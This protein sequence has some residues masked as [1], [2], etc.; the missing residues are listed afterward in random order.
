MRAMHERLRHTRGA[1]VAF[2][3]IRPD[4]D[5][6]TYLGVGNIFGRIALSGEKTRSLVS[7]NGTLGHELHKVQPFTYPWSRDAV[8]VMNS[9]GLL[10]NWDLA[11]CPGLEAQH[12]ALVAAVAWRDYR[13]VTD[14]A[15][16]VAVRAFRR[17][18][19]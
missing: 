13:R 3:E 6:L 5:V 19:A 4:E 16:V 15:T 8:L 14:D 11:A 9:D 2:A 1:A 7:M 12:P 18:P 10:S 17:R